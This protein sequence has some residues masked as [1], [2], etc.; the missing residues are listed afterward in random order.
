MI[1]FSF[2]PSR[3]LLARRLVA[4]SILALCSATL[5]HRDAAKAATVPYLKGYKDFYSGVVP[6]EPGL[7]IRDDQVFYTG[8]INKTVIGGRVSLGLHEDL[9]ANAFSPTVVTS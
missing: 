7:Y 8:D 1:L 2:S 3:R 4:A 9:V 5:A 6:A